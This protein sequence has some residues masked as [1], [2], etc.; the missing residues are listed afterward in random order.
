MPDDVKIKIN[1]EPLLKRID[2]GA[3]E[4]LALAGDLIRDDAARRAPKATSALANS[5]QRGPVT[6]SVF[7]G[8]L[9]TVIAPGQEYGIYQEFGTGIY[10]PKGRRIQSRK[11]SKGALRWQL[12]TGEF[13][14]RKY[15]RGSKPQPFMRPAAE[16]NASKAADII[17]SAIKAKL[18]V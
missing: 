11:G 6:G 16:A 10:G 4:G 15:S 7:G 12:P 13:I 17:G 8:N 14:V 3:R 2:A 5:I 9:R 1:L 18:G